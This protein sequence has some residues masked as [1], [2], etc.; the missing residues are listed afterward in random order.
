MALALGTFGA[1]RYSLD[2]AWGVFSHWNGTTRLLVTAIV[3]V[4]G[5]VLQLAVFYRPPKKSPSPD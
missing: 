4:G 3:G 1:G 2:N 5:A